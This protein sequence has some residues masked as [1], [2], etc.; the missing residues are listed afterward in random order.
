MRY[1]L[2]EFDPMLGPQLWT[3]TTCKPCGGSGRAW[4]AGDHDGECYSCAGM[5]EQASN[6]FAPEYATGDRI[7]S[8]SRPNLQPERT[9][10]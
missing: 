7:G 1:Q 5:G 3:I 8:P 4:T 9:K 2:L 10:R 6:R